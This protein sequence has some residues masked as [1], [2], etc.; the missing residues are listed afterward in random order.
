MR[1][2]S[3]VSRRHIPAVKRTGKQRMIQMLVPFVASMDDIPRSAISDEVSKPS[4]NMT[5]SGYIFQGRSMSLNIPFKIANKHP[6][7]SNE[8]ALESSSGDD[9]RTLRS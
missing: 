9:W 6:A 4:P 8:K 2:P 1:A 3:V 5:P 7:P